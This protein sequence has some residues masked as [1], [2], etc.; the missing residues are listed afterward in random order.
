ML[1]LNYKDAKRKIRISN[2]KIITSTKNENLKLHKQLFS[3]ILSLRLVKKVNFQRQYLEDGLKIL[4]QGNSIS[5]LIKS[6][7]QNLTNYQKMLQSPATALIIKK[8]KEK[9]EHR[10]SSMKERV[11]QSFKNHSTAHISNNNKKGNSNDKVMV[12]EALQTISEKDDNYL[13]IIEENYRNYRVFRNQIKNNNPKGDKITNKT[14]KEYHQESEQSNFLYDSNN[15]TKRREQNWNNLRVKMQKSPTPANTN[16]K[17]EKD[18]E[19]IIPENQNLKRV[20]VTSVD[21]KKDKPK[22]E[23]ITKNEDRTVVASNRNNEIKKTKIEISPGARRSILNKSPFIKKETKDNKEI[24]DKTDNISNKIRNHSRLK[25][26]IK[27][28]KTFQV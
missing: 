5:Q 21:T 20:D 11:N 1:V 4:S 12:T 24:K 8:L 3:D 6:L 10:N 9:S 14:V 25:E 23:M 22:N 7:N 15:S 28:N 2:T 18:K 17:K 26:L 13:P 16:N 19:R 27:T